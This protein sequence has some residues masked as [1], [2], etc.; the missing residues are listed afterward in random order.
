MRLIYVCV[1]LL[2]HDNIIHVQLRVLV[3][4]VVAVPYECRSILLTLSCC[5]CRIYSFVVHN[6][7]V[8]VSCSLFFFS[9]SVFVATL[10]TRA[11]SSGWAIWPI[12][13]CLCACVFRDQ[14]AHCIYRT[15]NKVSRFSLSAIKRAVHVRMETLK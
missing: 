15:L 10:K 7:C 14:D 4:V 9:F 13:K 6:L 3:D 2:V 1:S 5:Y 11:A 12:R 8:S